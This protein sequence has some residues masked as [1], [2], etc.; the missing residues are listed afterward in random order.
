ML[1]IQS[2]AYSATSGGYLAPVKGIS[3]YYPT[4][5][6]IDASYLK[7]DFAKSSNWIEFLHNYM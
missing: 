3:I 6:K 4:T 2:V 5:G 7:T 1:L